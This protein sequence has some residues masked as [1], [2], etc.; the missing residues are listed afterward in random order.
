MG[1]MSDALVSSVGNDTY[2]Y[3]AVKGSPFA[4]DCAVFGLAKDE[5]VA[6][7]ARFPNSGTEVVNGVIIKGS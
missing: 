7:T 6:L 3:V 5:V 1:T 4:T 2:H